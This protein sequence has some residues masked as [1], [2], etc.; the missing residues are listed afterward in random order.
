MREEFDYVVA[1][2][3]SQFVGKAARELKAKV[4]GFVENGYK[5]I[6]GVSITVEHGYYIAAQALEKEAVA[7]D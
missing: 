2:S 7:Y 4:L 1:W 5:P 6:G 3:E